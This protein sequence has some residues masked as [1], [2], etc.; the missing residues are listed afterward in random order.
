MTQ[1]RHRRPTA[2]RAERWAS[3]GCGYT[4]EKPRIVLDPPRRPG[5]PVKKNIPTLFL[6]Y[7]RQAR[8]KAM[9]HSQEKW[10]QAYGQFYSNIIRVYRL[11]DASL[12]H[13]TVDE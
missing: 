11:I 2:R 13:T 10:Q 1:R 8:V 12:S 6:A 3:N 4:G 9:T 5:R 7:R